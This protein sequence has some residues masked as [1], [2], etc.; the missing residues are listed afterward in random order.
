MADGDERF[1]PIVYVRGYAGSQAA[2]EATV[3]TPYMGFELGSMKLRQQADGGIVRHVFESPLIR[4]GKDHGYRD[5]YHRGDLFPP[6]GEVPERSIWIFRYYDQVSQELPDEPGERPEI[7]DYARQ[8]ADFLEEIRTRVCGAKGEGR[9]VDRARKAFRVNLVAHSM[10]GLIART[11]LQTVA[12]KRRGSVEV[13]KVFTYGTPHGGIDLKV[14]GNLLNRLPV[15]NTENFSRPHMRQYL[16]LGKDDDVRSLGGHFPPDR[17][18]CL[19]GTNSGDYDAAGGMSR[20][21]VGPMSDG[22]VRITNAYVEGGPRAYVH[23]SHSGDFGLV[24]SEDGYQN[25]RRF[26]FGD[27]A[28]RIELDVDDV[29]L[30]PDIWDEAEAGREISASYHVEVTAKVRGANWDL[31]RRSAAEASAQF[32]TYERIQRTDPI[33]LVTGY[34]LSSARVDDTEETLGFSLDLGVLVPQ[35]EVAGRLWFKDHYEG[36]YIFR[37]KFNLELV[38]GDQPSLRWGRDSRTTNRTTQTV[39][40]T[41]RRDGWEFRI[42]VDGGSHPRLEGALVITSSPWNR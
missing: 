2:V 31:H 16:G 28:F 15:N 1:H 34:L 41:K 26:L 32:L 24:N 40:G 38:P 19:V 29:T 37:D 35:Y 20:R 9:A 10:G 17:F 22:L 11:Y 39:E 14:V 6:P 4:L 42:P 21:A 33:T 7:E 25:L 18:F 5:V 23:R 27:H 12:P 8:L 13:D 36:G 3:S 30:P